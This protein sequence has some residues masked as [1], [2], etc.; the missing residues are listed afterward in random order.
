MPSTTILGTPVSPK[1]HVPRRRLKE[2]VLDPF[3]PAIGLR[4]GVVPRTTADA[5]AQLRLDQ[6]RYPVGNPKRD[7]SFYFCEDI[8][9]HNSDSYCPTHQR[10][11]SGRYESI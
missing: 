9:A 1:P 2:H 8:K 3:D 11:C 4:P 10:F 5:V 7:G 6:C